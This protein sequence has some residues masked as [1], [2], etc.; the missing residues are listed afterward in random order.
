MSCIRTSGNLLAD[1]RLRVLVSR[2]LRAAAILCLAAIS[3]CERPSEQTVVEI[4]PP[5]DLD[6]LDRSVRTSH[7][8]MRAL[9][10]SMITGEDAISASTLAQAYVLAGNWYM[11]FGFY[12]Q[13]LIAFEACRDVLPARAFCRYGLAT[14]HRYKGRVDDAVREYDQVIA[15]TDPDPYMPALVWAAFLAIENGELDRASTLLQ[16]AQPLDSGAMTLLGMARVAL[17]RDDAV[18][19][20]AHLES[21]LGRAP[22]ATT[23]LYALAQAERALGNDVRYREI[24]NEL[25][26]DN[27]DHKALS[28]EDPWLEEIDRV[29]ITY[30]DL[31]QQGLLAK[32]RGDFQEAMDKF[33]MAMDA[34]KRNLDAQLQLAQVHTMLDQPAIAREIL[35]TTKTQFPDSPRVYFQLSRTSMLLN[36]MAAAESQIAYAIEMDPENVRYALF[37]AEIWL[38]NGRQKAALDRLRTLRK[39]HDRSSE[40]ARVF[41][42]ALA[43][44]GMHDEARMELRLAT[45]DIPESS[46]LA[47]LEQW[48]RDNEKGPR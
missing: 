24:L 23:L 44:V 4:P 36:A 38:R 20:Q 41:V 21:A 46:D 19:A 30:L 33:A 25:P 10:D 35:T 29:G 48:I 1:S 34:D 27:K 17:Q 3:G 42:Q 11:A 22:G 31:M 15:L 14:L 16:Q 45:Q 28:I 7:E 47:Q 18:S 13:A 40:V 26:R 9:F 37:E 32:K 2:S 39:K 6:Q 5:S 8:E 43:L 12:Q